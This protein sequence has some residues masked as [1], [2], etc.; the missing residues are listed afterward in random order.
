MEGPRLG[1]GRRE[2]TASMS[3]R[4]GGITIEGGVVYDGLGGA[5]IAA[6]IVIRGDRIAAVLPRDEVG[7]SDPRV[8]GEVD[9]RIDARNLAV[10]PGFIDLH[11]HSDLILMLPPE[12]RRSLQRG[13]LAQGITTEIAGN[14]GLAPIPVT[15]SSAAPVRAVLSWMTPEGARPL[16]ASFADYLDLCGETPLPMNAGLL[17]AH[18]PIRAAVL[19]MSAGLAEGAAL[20]RMQDLVATACDAGAF[21]LSA[22]LI[23]PPGMRA[24]TGELVALAAPL[25]GA[26][27][28]FTCHVRGSSETLLPA[29]RELIEVGRRSGCRVHHSHSEAVGP[30]HWSK[31]EEVLEIEEEARRAGVRVSFDLFPYHA[32]ATM[33]AAIYPPWAL[34]GGMGSLLD[35]LSRPSERARIRRAVET[36]A[37]AWPPWSEGGWPHNLVLACG[38]DRIFVA[39]TAAGHPGRA[40]RS[41]ARGRGDHDEGLSLTELGKQRS[42]DPFDAVSDL[43]IEEEGQVGQWIFGIS[44]EEGR[45]APMVA[46]LRSPHGAIATDACD[47]GAGLPHPA[48]YGTFPRILARF[49]RERGI[50]GLPE[51]IRRMTSLPASI[52]GISGR[53]RI[54]PGLAAD[55][56]VFDPASIADM[57]TFEA[58]R[59]EAVG[60]LHVLINGTLAVR[61]GTVSGV[62]GGR[63]LRR[64][65]G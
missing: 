9:V 43:M 41:G 51:A 47:Y 62:D 49:V 37:P 50:L 44:G 19:G 57:A 42:R 13:K 39:R 6:D 52:L 8:P 17:A 23:Y 21:G 20:G 10:C 53:G 30:D 46:L 33:M 18:G 64:G 40:G 59:R 36:Q 63:L 28:V 11:S 61:D 29:V 12:T 1:N 32:A 26:G 56:V 38:Y 5:G 7:G 54:A 60:I 3:G 27:G 35:R 22:G 48:A 25:A 34:E 55:V 65:R 4:P 14:C 2:S 15:E 31:I 45:D 16:P 58:P 24:D